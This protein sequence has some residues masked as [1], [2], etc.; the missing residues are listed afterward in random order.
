M[1]FRRN[2][3]VNRLIILIDVARQRQRSSTIEENQT[4]KQEVKDLEEELQQAALKP[5]DRLTDGQSTED[6]ETASVRPIEEEDG[7]LW[8]RQTE[9]TPASEDEDD[10]LGHRFEEFR[11]R[12]ELEQQENNWP[13]N[14]LHHEMCS[15][16]LYVNSSVQQIRVCLIQENKPCLLL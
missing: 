7:A 10:W 1:L 9:K 8:D 4:L 6:G 16:L 12:R 14:L 15:C 11:R 5:L 13:K 2:R 3:R